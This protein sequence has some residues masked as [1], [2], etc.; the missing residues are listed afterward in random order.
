MTGVKIDHNT[1]VLVGDGEK[2]LIFNNEGDDVFPNLQVIRHLEIENPKTSDQGTDA[3][4]RNNSGPGHQKSAMEPTDWHTMEKHRFAKGMAD[5]LY[6]A[7]HKGRFDKL[8]VAAPPMILGDLRKAFHKEVKDRVVAE[9]HKTLTGHP[10]L[11][12]ERILTQKA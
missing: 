9:V 3:P 2:A 12:I 5:M 4:G 8:V 6:K 11:E 7:A 1:W 10:P